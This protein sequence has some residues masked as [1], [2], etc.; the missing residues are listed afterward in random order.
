MAISI[1][2][3]VENFQTF[4]F[5]QLLTLPQID[6][7]GREVPGRQ[8]AAVRLRELLQR[9]NP[10][11]GATHAMLTSGDGSFSA[12]VPLHDVQDALLVYR[13]GDQ[14]LPETLG[15]PVRFLIP[16]PGPCHSGGAD[17]CANVKHLA[18]IE[19]TV[20]E[21]PDARADKPHV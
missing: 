1:I 15:G 2:G 10:K 8:G 20:G 3:E 13:L 12:S 11:P 19:L 9:A 6:D 5:A 7:V 16:D 17:V 21:R 14:P 18:R 4:G